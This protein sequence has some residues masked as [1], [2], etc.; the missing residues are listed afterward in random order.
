MKLI[1]T[2]INMSFQKILIPTDGSDN[3]LP[4]IR[5]GFKIAQLSNGNVTA[6]HVTD[7]PANDEGVAKILNVV[8]SMGKEL[9]VEVTPLVRS[10]KPIDVIL[11]LSGEHDVIVMGSLGRTGLGKALIGSVAQSVIAE[12]KCPVTVV[13]NNEVDA[14]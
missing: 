5:A 11:D 8:I 2:V 7:K 9:G 4:A 14:Q 10:G 12:A 6:L 1:E 3:T 13:K